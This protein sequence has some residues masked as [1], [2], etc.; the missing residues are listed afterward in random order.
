LAD[1]VGDE[2]Q[3]PTASA[4]GCRE[5]ERIEGSHLKRLSQVAG[6]LTGGCVELLPDALRIGGNKAAL[7]LRGVLGS[8]PP[9]VVLVPIEAAELDGEG[10]IVAQRANWSAD[11]LKVAP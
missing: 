8:T 7:M 6:S 2:R 5:V 1:V 9:H 3:R 4:F 10:K 11:D